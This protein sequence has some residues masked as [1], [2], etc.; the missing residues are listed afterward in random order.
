MAQRSQHES[1]TKE[2][3]S[4]ESL[5]EKIARGKNGT[6]MKK[7]HTQI[8]RHNR[9]QTQRICGARK[10]PNHCK[11]CLTKFLIPG[12]NFAQF[13]DVNQCYCF[14]YFCSFGIFRRFRKVLRSDRISL[15]SFC[16]LVRGNADS[17]KKRKRKRFQ[18]KRSSCT[19]HPSN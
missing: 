1:E 8:M 12:I 2:I 16:L 17:Q 10:I 4:I 14:N 18:E 3:R 5:P 13:P 19:I 7:T 11:Y 9:T 6:K 15:H